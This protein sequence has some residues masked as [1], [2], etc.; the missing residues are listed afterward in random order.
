MELF[1]IGFIK[2]PTYPPENGMEKP[3][4]KFRNRRNKL[5]ATISH[6]NYLPSWFSLSF[7]TYIPQ[8]YEEAPR[9]VSVVALGT[10]TWKS[11]VIWEHKPL[12]AI[13]SFVLSNNTKS[14]TKLVLELNIWLS[15]SLLNFWSIY[16]HLWLVLRLATF[17]VAKHKLRVSKHRLTQL[18]HVCAHAF[19]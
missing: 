16:I 6:K 17:R 11:K 5:C 15:L 1:K 14:A 8:S 10:R 13:Q 2:Y 12:E 9:G 18:T 7:F 3:K 19:F 4:K